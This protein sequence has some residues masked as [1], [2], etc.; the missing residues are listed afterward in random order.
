MAFVNGYLS[1]IT[2]NNTVK[3]FKGI[4]IP[5]L[6]FETLWI[7]FLFLMKGTINKTIY[8]IPELGL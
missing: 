1:K 5:Y 4:F 6:L 3:S 7:V 2:P 8:M